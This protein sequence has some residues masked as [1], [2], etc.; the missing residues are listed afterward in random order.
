MSIRGDG[1]EGQDL[2]NEAGEWMEEG[3]EGGEK[4]R[5]GGRVR[6]RLTL[7]DDVTEDD[8]EKR[9]RK[10]ADQAAR[11]VCGVGRQGKDW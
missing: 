8:D 2:V 6:G 3:R 7:R 5:E 9:G 10:E 1:A 11:Q 4:K